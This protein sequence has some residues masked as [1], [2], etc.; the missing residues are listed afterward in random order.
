LT[1][2]VFKIKAAKVAGFLMNADYVEQDVV[3]TKDDIPIVLHDI[4]IGNNVTPNLEFFELVHLLF[5]FQ[6][7]LQ[8]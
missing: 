4:H 7:Q 5:H 3:L 8:M 6:I 1:H 2:G